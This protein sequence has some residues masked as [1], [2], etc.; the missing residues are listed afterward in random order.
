MS[1]KVGAMP[2]VFPQMAYED[3]IKKVASI[4]FELVELWGDGSPW[5]GMWPRD[6]KGE[7]RSHLKEIIEENNLEVSSIAFPCAPWTEINLAAANPGIREASVKEVEEA[8][9]AGHY[10]GA[11]VIVLQAGWVF[12]PDLLPL[13][14]ARKYAAESIKKCASFA[15]GYGVKIALE[16]A[17]TFYK[18]SDLLWFIQEVDTNNVGTCLDL[19][20]AAKEGIP[21]VKLIKDLNKTIL[22]V[23]LSDTN[24]DS[25][26]PIGKGKIDFKSALKALKEINYKGNFVFEIFGATEQEIIKSKKI[27]EELIAECGL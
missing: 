8:V 3:A 17:S 12:S 23:H 22:D 4:G 24:K 10:L 14:Q 26:L 2:I 13:K 9:K 18:A 1:A 15:N 16:N 21:L 6:L 27:I 20:H 19:C 5:Q 25:N 7:K 11:K